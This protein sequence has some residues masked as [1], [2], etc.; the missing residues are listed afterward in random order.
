[1][2]QSNLHRLCWDCGKRLGEPID[3]EERRCIKAGREPGVHTKP[4]WYRPYKYGAY[5][6]TMAILLFLGGLTFIAQPFFY[7]GAYYSVEESAFARDFYIGPVGPVSYILIGLIFLAFSLWA[8]HPRIVEVLRKKG[9]GLTA[10]EDYPSESYVYIRRI[11]L[12]AIVVVMLFFITMTCFFPFYYKGIPAVQ[13]VV[14][15]I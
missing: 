15:G 10:D 7:Y 13:E 12:F 9:E 4:K 8:I 6:R 2:V 1:M 11:T 5:D 3:I 14:S